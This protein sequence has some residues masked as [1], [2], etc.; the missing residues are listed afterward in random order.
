M[1]FIKYNIFGTTEVSWNCTLGKNERE[2]YM[3]L[4]DT[5]F[6]NLPISYL[7]T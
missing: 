4:L 7:K 3:Q 2:L 6:Q 5:I 1:D